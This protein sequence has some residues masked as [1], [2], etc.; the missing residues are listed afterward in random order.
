[1]S[2]RWWPYSMTDESPVHGLVER[3]I[4]SLSTEVESDGV[5]TE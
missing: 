4:V 1:M 3:S 2:L 5:Q